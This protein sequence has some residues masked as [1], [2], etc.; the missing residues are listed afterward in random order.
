[1]ATTSET[2]KRALTR[3]DGSPSCD[4]P[5]VR[6]RYVRWSC[7]FRAG[8]GVGLSVR[9]PHCS[10]HVFSS[11]CSRERFRS[12]SLCW[13]ED[14]SQSV[15]SVAVSAPRQGPTMPSRV[16][17]NGNW[18]TWRHRRWR[19]G[20]G[21]PASPPP[22]RRNALYDSGYGGV[23]SRNDDDDGVRHAHFVCCSS[24]EAM[25]RHHLHL[26]PRHQFCCTKFFFDERGIF[27]SP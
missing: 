15:S 23:R 27:C 25:V 14:V 26:H 3:R 19:G 5:L 16:P 1:V 2:D 24:L 6:S 8:C 18:R 17:G 22:H 10:L 4:A 9:R 11:L 7:S 21:S 12:A 13:H 20:E